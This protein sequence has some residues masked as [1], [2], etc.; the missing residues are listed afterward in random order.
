MIEKMHEIS[1][2]TEPVLVTYTQPCNPGTDYSTLSVDL[3]VGWLISGL[4]IRRSPGINLANHTRLILPCTSGFLEA[5]INLPLQSHNWPYV[6]VANHGSVVA[7]RMIWAIAL[8]SV[9]LS[10]APIGWTDKFLSPASRYSPPVCP[11]AIFKSKQ[12]C[13]TLFVRKFATEIMFPFSWWIACIWVKENFL[14]S[15][16]TSSLLYSL[17]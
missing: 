8:L 7:P 12:G 5:A 6:L 16:M 17:N 11:A 2:H 14:Y 1:W 9:D 3:S 10:I 15:Y 13:V 4:F